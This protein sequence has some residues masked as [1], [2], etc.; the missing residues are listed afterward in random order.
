MPRLDDHY[1]DVEFDYEKQLAQADAQKKAA[2]VR[3]AASS[4]FRR[5]EEVCKYWLRG[6]C[7]MGDECEYL[8]EFDHSRVPE[9]FYYLRFGECH[10]PE[11]VFR[12]VSLE[13]KIPECAAY[14][15]GFCKYGAQCRLRHV[16]RD[17][18][19]NYLAGLCVDGNRCR[20]GHP[21]LR[22]YTR[23]A[24][25][26]RL[27]NGEMDEPRVHG[28]Q[29]V[30]AI[31]QGNSRAA[32][33]ILAHI[34]EPPNPSGAGDALTEELAERKT[35]YMQYRE[36]AAGVDG[37]ERARPK[38]FRCGE[39][40]HVSRECPLAPGSVPPMPPDGKQEDFTTD[41]IMALCEERALARRA[42][43]FDEADRIRE[44]LRRSGVTLNDDAR[45]WRHQDGREGEQR[46]PPRHPRRRP[47]PDRPDR[48]RPPMDRPPL[49]S[50]GSA[51]APLLPGGVDPASAAAGL[52]ALQSMAANLGGF[53]AAGLGALGALPGFGALGGAGAPAAGGGGATLDALR[54]ALSAFGAQTPPGAPY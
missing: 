50:P 48:D 31:Q 15:R 53:G 35:R 17:A 54:S 22:Y 51:Q 27:Q 23:E 34:C 16:K 18:C 9:C 24:V 32:Q 8:H 14:A 7:R 44:R 2:A 30:L 28:G 29:M 39:E 5:P 52:Q 38:C 36:S 10:N 25:M 4:F 46:E 21:R 45:T 43:E 3:S 42:R 20:Y 13:E 41:E 37:D 40:G 6:L 26:E 49:P 11:C 12:H 19:P 33:E 1:D 47:P